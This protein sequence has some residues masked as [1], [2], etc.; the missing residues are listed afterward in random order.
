MANI[1]QRIL[2]LL[3]EIEGNGSFATSGA[4]TIIIPGLHIQG[5]G[6]VSIPLLPSQAKEI[7]QLANKAPF[8]MGSKTIID[9]NVRSAWEIDAGQISFLNKDWFGFLT[10]ITKKVKEGLGIENSEVIPSLYKFLIYEEGDFFL[11]H[12]D[13]EKEPGMFGTLIIG[14][15]SAHTGGELLIRFDGRKKCVDFSI[16]TNDYKMPYAA[17]FADCEH[18]IK[19]I[20]SGFRACIVYNLLQNVGSQ[21]IEGVHIDRYIGPM[22]D[23]LKSL[24][25]SIINTPKVILLD[26]QYTPANFSCSS[27]KHHDK[28]RAEVLF[29]AAARAG[30]YAELGLLTHYME[31]Q[32]ESDDYDYGYNYRNKNRKSGIESSMGEVYEEYSG[33]EYWVDGDI[34]SLGKIDIDEKEILTNVKIGKGKPIEEEEEGYTGNAG[35]T[36]EYWYHYGA[37]ILWPKSRHIDVLS[38]VPVSVKL[39]WLE[40]YLENWDN[41]ELNSKEYAIKLIICVQ[42]ELILQESGEYDFSSVASILS[43]LRDVHLLEKCSLMLANVFEKIQIKDWMVL[44]E[45]Y[46]PASLALVV[47]LAAQRN[48]IFVVV[49]FLELILSLNEKSSTTLGA[50]LNKYILQMPSYLDAIN[51]PERPGTDKHQ[52]NKQV[53]SKGTRIEILGKVIAL[54]QIQ[55]AN[56]DWIDNTVEVI[57]R[58]M[59]REYVNNVL[60][61]AVVNKQGE[62]AEKLRQKCQ[63][64][65]KKRTAEKPIPPSDWRRNVP[66]VKRDKKVWQILKPFLESPTQEI[67]EYRENETYRNEMTNAIT[68]VTV[69]LAMETIKK[70]SPYTL[71]LT[72]TQAS[73]EM[74]LRHWKEDVALLKS[75]LI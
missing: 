46:Q 70:G 50:F 29:Q 54:S 3:N 2:D 22:T 19:Q 36:L 75:L 52:R 26:H 28:P 48:D 17:F 62:L 10:K 16:Q 41:A 5:I 55:T 49:H 68:N 47:D 53:R 20:T 1:N 32:L 37:V 8:G 64:D 24:S 61:V 11:P 58:S 34:P 57:T 39:K 21:K 31:G 63:E 18:E 42:E 7:I 25:D 13:S 30:Y 15:P 38:T 45:N 69:D 33:I 72:K 23:L 51:L 65:L 43:K 14:L 6:E 56:A 59:P 67:F 12:I 9:T 74:N 60:L 66:E 40:Y 35:M 44:F 71:K 73:Y 4:D 27:L